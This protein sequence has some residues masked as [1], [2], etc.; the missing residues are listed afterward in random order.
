MKLRK[1]FEF[2]SDSDDLEDEFL[3]WV[4]YKLGIKIGEYLGGGVEGSV[5]SIDKFRAIK[6]GYSDDHSSQYLTN[7]NLKGIM[8]IYQ[9]GNIVVPKR[10]KGDMEDYYYNGIELLRN[11]DKNDYTIGYIIMEKV[12][13]PVRLEHMLDILDFNIWKDL[14]VRLYQIPILHLCNLLLKI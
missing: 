2:N 11:A 12:S 14:T 10:F 1:F 13:T 5:Y 8:K 7:K 6:F 3:S 9:T 4:S